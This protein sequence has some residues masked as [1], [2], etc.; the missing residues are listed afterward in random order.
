GRG[1][2]RGYI[3]CPET[4]DIL[5]MDWQAGNIV[6]TAIGQSETAVTPLQMAA[7]AMTIANKGT[8]YQTYMVDSVYTY[9]MESLVSKTEPVIAAQIPDKTGYTFDTVIAGMKQ[10][11]DFTEYNYPKP[12][13]SDYYTGKYIL[14]D[15]PYAAAIKTGTPQM[16][17]Q[18]DTG[19]AFIG[20]YPA[21]D[22]EIAFAGFIEHGEY[23]KFMV[24][25]I[26]EAYYNEDYE[27]APLSEGYVPKD[28][29]PAEVLA[30]TDNSDDITEETYYEELFTE[31]EAPEEVSEEATD[32]SETQTQTEAVTESAQT[33][34]TP[35]TTE[36]TPSG[37]ET[38]IFSDTLPPAEMT[39]PTAPAVTMP[40]VTEVEQ[41][42]SAAETEGSA[43]EVTE[44]S[45]ENEDI[46]T[47]T[48]TPPPED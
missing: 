20:F 8:R 1:I 44:G 18:E 3:A 31:T 22:P 47:D 16:T 4:Y 11:A 25:Q 38:E 34:V 32:E 24:R 33:E 21:D 19:S 29:D 26:I 46:P 2:K 39:A 27:I 41:T 45:A 35:E 10:A 9:N 37:S 6:Q 17:S 30:D 40:P 12:R 7:Q 28:H 23:S 36:T 48:D 13:E 43:A 14:S 15:L 42:V 5:G